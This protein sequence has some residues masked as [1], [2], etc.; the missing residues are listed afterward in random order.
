MASVSLSPNSITPID[1]D[2]YTIHHSNNPSTI[3]VTF[4]LTRDNYGLWSHVVTMALRAEKKNL[5]L[6]MGPSQL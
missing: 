6:L 2:S 5:D 3:L 4:L 1:I